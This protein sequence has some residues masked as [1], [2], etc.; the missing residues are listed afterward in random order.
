MKSDHI[1]RLIAFTVI[2]L[3]GFHWTYIKQLSWI[4]FSGEDLLREL[5]EERRNLGRKKGPHKDQIESRVR[6]DLKL[7]QNDA[8]AKDTTFDTHKSPKIHPEKYNAKLEFHKK[9]NSSEIMD[10]RPKTQA[11]IRKEKFQLI[12]QNRKSNN[13]PRVEKS[14]KEQVV[15]TSENQFEILNQVICPLFEMPYEEQLEAKSKAHA[16][17]LARLG[18]VLANGKVKNQCKIISSDVLTEYR[19]K[20]EFGIQ[21]VIR[22]RSFRLYD[23]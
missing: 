13:E 2:T 18:K 8:W 19:S 17:F 4:G 6:S 16:D 1:K 23:F 12:N 20:D 5:E 11:Q 22:I 21:K 10:Q 7:K 14:E 15:I 9:H 3:S